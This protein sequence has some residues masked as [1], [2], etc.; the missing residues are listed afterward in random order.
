MFH[1]DFGERIISLSLIT[2][3]HSSLG[4]HRGLV[5]GVPWVYKRAAMVAVGWNLE[6]CFSFC[7][8]TCVSF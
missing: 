8:R 4:L 6:S 2:A 3:Q 5:P 1:C 7:N